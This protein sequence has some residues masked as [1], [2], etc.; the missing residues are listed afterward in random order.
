MI[1]KAYQG[2][3]TGPSLALPSER[4]LP[5]IGD[6]VRF[7]EGDAHAGLYDVTALEWEAV[8]IRWAAEPTKVKVILVKRYDADM[9]DDAYPRLALPD[10][11]A[12]LP[13][14]GESV[15]FTKGDPNDG[16]HYLRCEWDAKSGPD[17]RQA[18]L[19]DVQLVL[20]PKS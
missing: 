9:P 15:S 14:H 16:M 13:R 17:Q 19:F 10:V 6:L 20:M 7:G 1:L 8:T 3:E 18:K 5:R 2:D 11:A 4:S 12:M